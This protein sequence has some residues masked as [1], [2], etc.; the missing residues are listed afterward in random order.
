M[1]S[2]SP[3]RSSFFPSSPSSSS[4]S[5][6]P[7]TPARHARFLNDRPP[8]HLARPPIPL[9]TAKKAAGRRL[10]LYALL[11]P[12]VL[13]ALTLLSRRWQQS[14]PRH[15]APISLFK[16]ADDDPDS[17]SSSLSSSSTSTATESTTP[18]ATGVPQAPGADDPVIVPTPFPQPFDAS[19]SANFTTTTCRDFFITFTQSKAFRPCRSF[20]LLF[21]NSRAFFQAQSNLTL[22]NSIMWGTCN[23]KLSLD[24]CTSTMTSLATQLKS[25]A[26]TA[27]LRAGNALALAALVGF[28]N[29][30]LYRE[31]G[32][33]VNPRSNSYCY[34]EAL[35][36][37]S[38][39]DV[40]MY[41]LPL[42]VGL[43]DSEGAE[44]SCSRCGQAVM[45]VMQ[46]WAGNGSLP[47]SKTYPDAQ[48][49][50]DGRCGADYALPAVI[51]SG[52]A[53]RG[54]SVALLVAL[55]MATL[56]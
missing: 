46:S 10:R 12:L 1:R 27:D 52:A 5:S 44:P 51:T 31:A 4:S 37:S 56:V 55:V 39:N 38:P 49:R 48:N 9:T 14:R 24:T 53:A 6:S 15:H 42:G 23:T 35:A 22:M 33:I 40:Y 16:R 29:Y 11:V 34:L 47:I 17:S 41:N 32:C 7:S 28:S 36:S 18:V 54:V 43:P 2:P 21:A 13:V 3:T 20:G 50:T 19:L 30:A 25:S 26:C 8:I 45:G